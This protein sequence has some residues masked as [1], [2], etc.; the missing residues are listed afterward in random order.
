[1][2][3]DINLT[4]LRGTVSTPGGSDHDQARALWNGDIDRRPALIARCEAADDVSAAVRFA[5]EHGLELA[6]RGGG[7]SFS[8]ASVCDDGLMID[9][10]RMNGVTVDPGTRVA[11][12]GGGAPLS[13]LDAATQAHGL[14]VPAGTISHTGAFAVVGATSGSSRRSTSARTRSGRSCT[15]GCSS[16]GSTAGPTRCGWHGRWNC[17]PTRA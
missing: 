15:S 6:V 5:R 12:C 4:G 1:M 11:V 3:V 13:A 16:S 2:T 10:S 14:A 7:H 9:L 8:G 17:R